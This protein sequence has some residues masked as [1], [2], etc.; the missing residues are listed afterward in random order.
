MFCCHQLDD[1]EGISLAPNV[2]TSVQCSHNITPKSQ[3]RL[4]EGGCSSDL[5][6]NIYWMQ[7][8]GLLLTTSKR[9]WALQRILLGVAADTLEIKLMSLLGV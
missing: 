3:R 7:G 5:W 6:M 4:N 2:F 9:P 1:M 8:L